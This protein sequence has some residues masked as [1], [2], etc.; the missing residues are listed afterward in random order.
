[1]FCACETACQL[2]RGKLDAT[3]LMVRRVVLMTYFTLKN[4][5]ADGLAKFVIIVASNGRRNGFFTRAPSKQ[6]SRRITS[7]A[8]VIHLDERPAN[9]RSAVAGA[10]NHPNCLVLPFRME[11]IRPAA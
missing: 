10:C 3:A 7:Q 2:K 11:L 9:R 6:A 1:L 5:S 8:E 4:C